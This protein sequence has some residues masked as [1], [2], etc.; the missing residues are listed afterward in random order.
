MPNHD[1]L[2]KKKKTFPKGVKMTLKNI[3]SHE[4]SSAEPNENMR[5]DSP[6][7]EE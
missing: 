1:L 2:K 5:D 4:S 3:S 7:K 6:Q